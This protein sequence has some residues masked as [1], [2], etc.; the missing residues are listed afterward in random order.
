MTQLPALEHLMGAYFH[1]DWDLAGSEE[2]VVTAFLT[3]SPDLRDEI[4]PEIDGVLSAVSDEAEL[5]RLVDSMGCE[6][7][8]GPR[9]GSYRAWLAA[10]ADHAR[11]AHL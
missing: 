5:Q 7:L 10:I 1:Q 9:F 11:Q 3:G 6:Y 4:A 2:Q 8:P